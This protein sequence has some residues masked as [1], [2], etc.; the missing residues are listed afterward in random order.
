MIP[1]YGPY[2]STNPNDPY[3][4]EISPSP[5][6]LKQRFYSCGHPYSDFAYLEM[7]ALVPSKCPCCQERSHPLYPPLINPFQDASANMQPAEGGPIAKK[8][9]ATGLLHGR[10]IPINNPQAKESHCASCKRQRY[11]SDCFTGLR[12]SLVYFVA[13]GSLILSICFTIVEFKESSSI[14][15]SSPVVAA[16]KWSSRLSFV[17]MTAAII[18][19]HYNGIL[20]P[21]IS[22]P[23]TFSCF[24]LGT[25][26]TFWLATSNDS[27]F[28]AATLNVSRTYH[29]TAI[30][31]LVMLGFASAGKCTSKKTLEDAFSSRNTLTSEV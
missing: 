22:I 18:S 29:G 31:L 1:N 7:G 10:E 16:L 27:S 17:T 20:C 9:Y 15:A 2:N 23:L 13:I 24:A 8:D 28:F 14:S 5:P 11:C 3:R 21:I 12:W 19:M 4:C 26:C 25:L 6:I 30:A